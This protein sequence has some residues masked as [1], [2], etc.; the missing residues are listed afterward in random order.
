MAAGPSAT[1]VGMP[2]DE[3]AASQETRGVV[4][5]IAFPPDISGTY[6]YVTPAGFVHI[7]FV[8]GSLY[9]SRGQI[10]G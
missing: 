2:H 10:R 3:M 7:G 4:L 6:V 1:I 8:L 5:D 9:R